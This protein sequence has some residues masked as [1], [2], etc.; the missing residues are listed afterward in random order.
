[1]DHRATDVMITNQIDRASNGNGTV[2][3]IA[4]EEDLHAE[5]VESI[6]KKKNIP[7]AKVSTDQFPSVVGLTLEWDVFGTAVLT[8]PDKRKL[9]REEINAVWWRRPTGYQIDDA[10]EGK[11][12]REFARINCLHA[13]ESFITILPARHMNDIWMQRRAQR[14]GLQLETARECGLQIPYTL[15]S[16]EPASVERATTSHS[17]IIYKALE[18]ISGASDGTKLL[19][20][21]DL[22]RLS[23][24]R[25]GPAIFQEFIQPGFDLRIFIIG[26][27]I[28]A[29]KLSSQHVYGKIDIRL[30]MGATIEP[31]SLPKEVKA[32]LL[33]LMK[34]LGLVFGAIDMK[35]DNNGNYFFLEVNPA[36]QWIYIEME[37][38]Q[39]IT[40]CIA[41]WLA[42][43]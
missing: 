38:G 27:R 1:M 12:T 17:D 9:R 14:K 4:N 24:L 19:K 6:L 10:I 41:D 31:F 29:A 2:L 16:N 21:D 33:E 20:P 30:D 40:E 28:Y 8:L 15:I 3:I 37:T 23:Q 42:G 43:E 13:F 25:Y 36:G 18:K 35:V 34:K 5:A 22:L 11:T 26:E 7:V 39:P 32:S